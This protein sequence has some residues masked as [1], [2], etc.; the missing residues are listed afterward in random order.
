MS[1]KSP[2]SPMTKSRK[3]CKMLQPLQLQI[4]DTAFDLVVNTHAQSVVITLGFSPGS[5][6]G[7]RNQHSLFVVVLVD[8]WGRCWF[9]LV[10]GG[11]ENTGIFKK[12]SKIYVFCS[13][14]M[15]GARNL[16]IPKFPRNRVGKVCLTL[17][18]F[19]PVNWDIVMV[20]NLKLKV[21]DKSWHNIILVKAKNTLFQEMTPKNELTCR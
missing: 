11:Y 12:S 9:S 10:F 14:E 6:P 8:R 16:V 13:K 1:F 21:G 20:V 4:L 19:W 17:K 18:Q 3:V 7:S 15:S 2:P 5:F